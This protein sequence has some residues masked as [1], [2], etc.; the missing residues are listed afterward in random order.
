M[1]PA[2]PS[3]VKR[4]LALDAGWCCPYC[5]APLLPLGAGLRCEA[6]GRHFASSDGVYR[7]LEEKRR[8]ELLPFLE[9]EHRVRR[10]EGFRATPGLPDRIPPGSLAKLWRRRARRLREGLGLAMQNLGRG[11]WRV[12]EVGAGCGWASAALA[13]DGHRVTAVDASLDPADGLRAAE[14]VLPPGV[15]LERA[16]A[17]MEALP[18]EAG[19]FDL[20]LAVDVLHHARRL[21][22]FLVELRRVTRRLGGL[23]VLE[24]PVYARREDGEADVARRMRRLRRRYGLDVPRENQPGY[25]VRSELASLFGQ[26]GYRLEAGSLA[27]GFL[28]PALD[29]AAALLGRSGLPSRPV[30]FARRDG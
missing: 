10:D 24:S 12:L 5:A 25:L 29:F 30:L 23:L 28:A 9:L 19:H 14:H 18:L 27:T 15:T 22:P 21:L 8:S 13:V 17:D 16:E 3:E 1:R 26:A 11:P 4:E 6:E 7:L 2:E 20:V